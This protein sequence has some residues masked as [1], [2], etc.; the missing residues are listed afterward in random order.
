MIRPFSVARRA[1]PGAIHS[2]LCST[3]NSP[4]FAREASTLCRPRVLRNRAMKARTQTRRRPPKARRSP[5]ERRGA[6]AGGRLYRLPRVNCRIRSQHPAAILAR[7]HLDFATRAIAP[8][9]GA[10]RRHHPPRLVLP[11]VDGPVIVVRVGLRYRLELPCTPGP[12]C[13]PGSPHSAGWFPSAGQR[14]RHRAVSDRK[15]GTLVRTDSAE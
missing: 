4:S 11:L 13:H 6:A 2:A 7:P 3:S 12:M 1:G 15:P 5:D 10:R 14:A 9:S 8:W